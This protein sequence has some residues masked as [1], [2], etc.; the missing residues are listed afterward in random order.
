M[1]TSN[2]IAW[3]VVVFFA[4]VGVLISCVVKNFLAAAYAATTMFLAGRFLF[5]E[6]QKEK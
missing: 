5:L 4:A 3:A 2:V 6:I 1:K